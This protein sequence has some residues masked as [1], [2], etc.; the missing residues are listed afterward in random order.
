MATSDPH[1][2]AEAQQGIEMRGIV[3]GVN[4]SKDEIVE[5]QPRGQTKTQGS[6]MSV[7]P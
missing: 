1:G 7:D 2:D 4:E 5:R 6:G 3:D